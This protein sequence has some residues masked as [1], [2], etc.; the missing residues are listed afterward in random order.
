MSGPVDLDLIK[1]TLA[2]R[3]DALVVQLYPAAM[4]D[5]RHWRMG[6]ISGERGQSLAITRY[7][8]QAGLWRDFSSGESGS[9]LDLIAHALF[10]G[11]V[12]HEVVDWAVQWCGL[13]T[14][15]PA[16][17]QRARDR[18]AAASAEADKKA[19]TERRAKERQA[20]AI[21]L[22]GGPID[23]TPADLYLRGRAI[24]C[25]ALGRTPRALRYAPEVYNA[26]LQAGLPAMVA[27]VYD[28][29]RRLQAAVHRTWL[30][31]DAGGVWRKDG[32]LKDAKMSLGPFGGGHIPLHRGAHDGPLHTLPAG[33]WIATAEGIENALSIAMARPALRTIAHISL[34]NLGRL[35]LP[36]NIGGLIIGAD[37]DAPGSPAEA[38]LQ[39][40]LARLTERG[41]AYEIVR[42][43]DGHKDMNDWLQALARP[44]VQGELAS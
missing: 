30:R 34:D 5:G 20:Q 44:P 3:I 37:N 24:D 12:S 1:A 15:S 7:G 38:G 22:S 2:A 27:Y 19:A 25:A 33:T 26:E 40:Q 39:R 31:R 32:R 28:P 42:A 21:W 6:S 23:R 17:Q 14:L 9:A 18:A 36:P 43:P 29:E 11:R 8:A 41:I 4:Q 35:K 10:G 13:G 16:E